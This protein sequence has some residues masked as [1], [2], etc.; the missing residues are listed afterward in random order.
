MFLYVYHTLLVYRSYILDINVIIYQQKKRH[1][2]L[3]NSQRGMAVNRHIWK[4]KLMLWIF[5][6]IEINAGITC[7]HGLDV[8]MNEFDGTLKVLPRPYVLSSKMAQFYLLSY[9]TPIT[10]NLK[11]GT[12]RAWTILHWSMLSSAARIL[13]NVFYIRI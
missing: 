1:K 13:H 5:D 2:L 9:A 8:W 11:L 4:D 3:V 6:T 10:F 12:F 7:S